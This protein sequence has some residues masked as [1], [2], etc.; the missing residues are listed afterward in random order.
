MRLIFTDKPRIIDRSNFDKNEKAKVIEAL[1][2]CSK[3]THDEDFWSTTGWF[4]HLHGKSRFGS[5]FI[6]RVPDSTFDEVYDPARNLLQKMIAKEEF[7]Y[8]PK[9]YDLTLDARFG[10]DGSGVLFAL[11]ITGRRDVPG[12]ANS[13]LETLAAFAK[14]TGGYVYT[15]EVIQLA[16]WLAFEGLTAPESLDELNELISYLQ[17]EIPA[18]PDAGD[19]HELLNAP[20][21]SPFHLSTADREVI[22]GVIEEVTQGKTRLLQKLVFANFNAIAVV[23]K[24]EHADRFLKTFLSGKVAS[25]LG[26]TLHERLNWQLEVDEQVRSRQL[27]E[28]VV[29]ALVIDMQAKSSLAGFDPYQPAN[30]PLHA[31]QV[32][33]NFE[34]HLVAAGMADP[35]S[36]ALAAHLLLAGAAPELLIRDVPPGLTL[37]KPGW[38]ALSRAVALIEQASPGSSRL[39]KYAQIMAF[40]ELAPV[41]PEQ[42]QLHQ[43]AGVMPVINWAVLN[44]VIPHRAAKDYDQA[45]VVTATACFK[46]YM[47][48]L[49]QSETGLSTP[50]PSRRKVGL[51]ELQK[52][53]P[54]GDYL[55]KKAYKLKFVE[56]LSENGWLALLGHSNPLGHWA[57]YHDYQLSKTDNNQDAINLLLRMRF[58]ILDLYLSGD[59]I[60]NGKFTQRFEAL[61]DFRPP[62]Q[63]FE[64]LSQLKPANDVFKQAVDNYYDSVRTALSSIIKMA[65]TSLPER[66]RYAL[67]NGKLSF[68]T[69][70]K[71]VNPLNPNQETQNARD[72]AISRHGIIVC[73]ENRTSLRAYEFFTLRGLFRERPELAALLNSTGIIN[74]NPKLSFTGSKFDFQPKNK[75]RNWPLDYAAYNEGSEARNGITSNIV[76]E[77]LWHLRLET[78]SVQPVPLFFS[79]QVNDIAELLLT[80]HPVAS[81]EEIYGSLNV[82]T[83]LEEWRTTK[84]KVETLLI[85]IVVPFKQC[86]EDIRSG[87]TDRVAEGIGGCVLDGLS[88]IGLMIGVG[89]SVASIIAKTGST[90]AKILKIASTVARAAVSVFNPLDGLPALAQGGFRYAKRGIVYVGKHSLNAIST[91]TGQ[92][93]KLAI[94]TDI[95]P[96]IKAGSLSDVRVAAWRHADDL[97]DAIDL[98]VLPRNKEWHALNI[99]T[100]GAWGPRLKIQGLG[101]FS[102]L[103]QLLGLSKP[104]SYTRGYLTKAIPHAKSKLDNAISTLSNA[105]DE[106]V[107]AVLKHVFGT[108]SAAAAENLV[109]N[110]RVMRSDLD[111]L[112]L[113][114]IE[115]RPA[116]DSA[117]A[118]L[119][120][121]AYM[122]WKEGLAGGVKYDKSATRF[123][124]VFPTNLDDHYKLNR[125]DDAAIGDVLVHEM[126][127]GGPN[128]FDMYYAVNFTDS[129]K[130]EFDAAALLDFARNPHKAHPNNLFN[131]HTSF[132]R[133]HFEL[134]EKAK[135]SFPQV[136]QDYPAL[137]NAESY[138][139]AVA[140]LDQ[141]KTLPDRFAANLQS[142][143]QGVKNTTTLGFIDGPVLLGLSKTPRPL[144]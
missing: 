3:M 29:A 97:G 144:P 112:K 98:A 55:E 86:I 143:E 47:E 20:E 1:I 128:T 138:L 31:T 110:M 45:Q 5:I 89:A 87:R 113:S 13:E 37:G 140:L 99:K 4:S 68:Y 17:S 56:G 139:L 63:A 34:D 100:G 60:E 81:R 122:R 101:D 6:P 105:P 41:S 38:M 134:F 117:V 141:R 18:A 32:R 51:E 103:R 129:L 72:E 80:H 95:H 92:L 76:V 123:L 69:V 66:D 62:A 50:P 65:I 67:T 121:P 137:A 91:A 14:I 58:S 44:S 25:N 30:A 131:P 9:Q 8:L 135:S 106:E 70:R 40:S 28:M 115:F 75:A 78:A 82:P 39:M 124:S 61:S 88:I 49:A 111:S 109:D 2:T 33:E 27:K 53:M 119:S 108:D 59:L 107:R 52:V 21:D 133:P 23:D 12:A 94:G 127:H 90:T 11:E 43:Q 54:A 136:V 73:C 142:I 126:S 77:K 83:E 35:D 48:A 114:N 96:L 74:D 22:T 7:S 102:R 104:H 118:A 130:G 42:I 84:E 125:Y 120:P 36:A 57:L 24:R 71:E 10:V 93:K 46:R 85:N 16:Q 19:Y 26:Q 116:T 15:G 79:P 64:K 132:H